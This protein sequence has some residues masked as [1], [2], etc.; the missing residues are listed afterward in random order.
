MFTH[1]SFPVLFRTAQ[2]NAAQPLLDYLRRVQPVALTTCPVLPTDLSAFD[3]VA[4]DDITAMPPDEQAH[5]ADYVRR[6]GNCLVFLGNGNGHGPDSVPDFMGVTLGK[7]GP[8]TELRVL[9]ADANNPMGVRLP[10]VFYFPN[11]YLPLCLVDDQAET[12]LYA[13]WHFQHTPV[14]VNNP[15]GDGRV[16]ST[17]LR[18]F[19]EPAFQQVVYRLLRNLAGRHTTS[20]TVNVGLLGYSPA[21]GRLHAMGSEAVTGLNFMAACDLSQARLDEAVADF[22]D[23][24]TYNSAEALAD[25]PDVDLVIIATPPNT[26]ARLAVQLLEAGKHVVCEKPLALTRAETVQMMATAERHNRLLV[27]HQNRR[28]DVDY[29]AIK[30]A[31]ADG[32]VGQPF[33][34]ETF[35][36][37]FNHPCGYWHSHAPISGGTT[38]DWGAHYLDWVLSLMPDKPVEVISTRQNRVWYD[39]TNAD[40]ERVQVRFAGGQEAELIHSDIA[41]IRKPKWYLLGDEGAIVG[42]W[43]DVKVYEPDPTLYFFEHKIPATE[44]PP[45][46]T[47]TR[48][49]SSGQLFEQTLP[50]PP[51]PTFGFHHNLADHLLSGEPLTVPVSDSAT[52][53]AVLEAAARSAANG[54]SVEQLDG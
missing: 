6:G 40:Q 24:Q 25:A 41:A 28:W 39:V 5:L 8:R 48:R 38:Y 29:L 36:G 12:V 23:I 4:T 35:V 51:R 26:H 52:V 9:F 7:P 47:V 37:D 10:D 20:Q 49:H 32:L 53:V 3:I 18:N 31:L 19:A 16:V 50:L 22:P 33:Y 43:R 15:Q 27:T 13:D 34:L 54:G 11:Q 44:M 2:P 17:T 42:R 1:P 30:Q 21:V 14:V 46:L 45:K